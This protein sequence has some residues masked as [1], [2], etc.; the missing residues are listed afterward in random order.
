[1]GCGIVG[2]IEKVEGKKERKRAED[3]E[4]WRKSVAANA[5]F[6]RPE[7]GHYTFLRNEPIFLG[8]EN[9]C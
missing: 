1:M 2:A 3:E 4:R 9:R 8:E 7:R 5:I 6:G